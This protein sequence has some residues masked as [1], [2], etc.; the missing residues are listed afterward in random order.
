[1]L[2][3]AYIPAKASAQETV[4]EEQADLRALEMEAVNLLHTVLIALDIITHL[5]FTVERKLIK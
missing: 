4:C 3:S 1:M 2:K 5:L